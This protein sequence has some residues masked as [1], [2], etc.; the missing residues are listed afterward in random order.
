MKVTEEQINKLDKL[1]AQE[2]DG[3]GVSCIRSIISYLRRGQY[4]DGLTCC[5]TDSDKIRNY[6]EIYTF[7]EE[8]FPEF[9]QFND[10]LRT[11]FG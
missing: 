7:M 2:N 6:P 11:L 8:I 10:R 9:K 1:Q 3:R 5:F 4:N